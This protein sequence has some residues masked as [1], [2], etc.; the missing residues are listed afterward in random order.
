MAVSRWHGLLCGIACCMAPLVAAADGIADELVRDVSEFGRAQ[1]HEL[2]EIL[3]RQAQASRRAEPEWVRDLSHEDLDPRSQPGEDALQLVLQKDRRDGADLLTLR[4]PLAERGAVRA[5]AGA[6][7]SKTVYFA[8]SPDGPALL[9]HSRRHRSYGAAAEF[10][11]DLRISEALMV[12]AELRWVEMDSD[13]V[14]LR[15]G[16]A[17]VGVDALGFGVSVGWRFR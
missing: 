11:A 17:L 7:L 13:A 15:A 9:R 12:N 5:Y 16:D 8:E 6:G 2:Q 1:L 10:G 4:Y 3:G 14:L